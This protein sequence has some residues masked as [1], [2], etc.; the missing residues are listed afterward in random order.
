MI[1]ACFS[2][3]MVR[4]LFRDIASD[5]LM[6]VSG[7]ASLAQ[8]LKDNSFLY[9]IVARYSLVFP[10]WFVNGTAAMV[11]V[12]LRTFASAT[13]ISVI[14]G[15]I[16]YTTAGRALTHVLDTLDEEGV[17]NLSTLE[18]LKSTILNS[19]ELKICAILMIL[20]ASVPL[21]LKRFAMNEIDNRVE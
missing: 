5:F 1:G 3:V 19:D 10:F 2:Y 4:T 9:L 7:Y 13:A 12:P 14:P 8:K 21:F 11:G 16:I 15:S 18:I 20:T 6:K 17:K